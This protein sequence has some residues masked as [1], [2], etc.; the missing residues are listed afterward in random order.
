M[1]LIIKREESGLMI[2]NDENVDDLMWLVTDTDTVFNSAYKIS[3]LAQINEQLYPLFQITSFGLGFASGIYFSAPYFQ[4]KKFN[5]IKSNILRGISISLASSGVGLVIGGIWA[6]CSVP[7]L[8]ISLKSYIMAKN[9]S[10]G[11]LKDIDTY[12]YSEE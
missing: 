5:F 9:V 7:Y 3:K 12:L 6:I 1:L 10:F 8:E 2:N 11:L 4:E